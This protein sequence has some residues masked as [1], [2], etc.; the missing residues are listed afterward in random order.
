LGR[1]IGNAD[2]GVERDVG[3]LAGVQ[4]LD[5]HRAEPAV[6]SANEDHGRILWSSERPESWHVRADWHHAR[7]IVCSASKPL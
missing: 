6:L 2:R 4:L 3:I 5:R 1:A 7:R